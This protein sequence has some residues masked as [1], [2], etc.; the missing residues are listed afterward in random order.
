MVESCDSVDSDHANEDGFVER[1]NVAPRITKIEAQEPKDRSRHQQ[2]IEQRVRSSSSML[3]PCRLPALVPSR[4]VGWPI[5]RKRGQVQPV[6]P[7]SEPSR[8]PCPSEKASYLLLPHRRMFPCS[9]RK[10]ARTAPTLL[11]TSATQFEKLNSRLLVV[12]SAY[13]Q[14]GSW[15][16]TAAKSKG[17]N[18]DRI[19]S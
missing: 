11:S 2:E 1:V 14:L 8:A 10:Q 5:C 3:H 4:P 17:G 9:H 16:D 7:S 18:V 12:T 6:P 13:P 15:P 19:G